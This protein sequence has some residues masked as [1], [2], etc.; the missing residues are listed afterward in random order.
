MWQLIE[1]APKD[2]TLILCAAIGHSNYT[3]IESGIHVEDPTL[4]VWWAR[5][6]RWSYRWK[7]FWDEIEP[8]GFANLSHWMNLP[9]P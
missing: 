5:S 3:D 1:T 2:G 8:S 7:K 6:G 9:K 4:R